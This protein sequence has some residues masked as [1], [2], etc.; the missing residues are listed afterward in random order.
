MLWAHHINWR[1]AQLTKRKRCG[2]PSFSDPFVS[3]SDARTWRQ[4]VLLEEPGNVK[5]LYRKADARVQGRV[6]QVTE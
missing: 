5:A 6:L 2:P 1:V 4:E 3:S